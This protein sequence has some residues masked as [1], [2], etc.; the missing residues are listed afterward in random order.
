LTDTGIECP[1]P[2]IL[3]ILCFETV[4]PFPSQAWAIVVRQWLALTALHPCSQLAICT[5]GVRQWSVLTALYPSHSSHRLTKKENFYAEKG[6]VPG[7][8]LAL[9]MIILFKM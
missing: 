4:T 5:V 7:G 9:F 1:I 6:G 2:L 8:N 3:V